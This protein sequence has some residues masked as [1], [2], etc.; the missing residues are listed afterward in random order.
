MGHRRKF[1]RSGTG[2]CL[3][4][5]ACLSLAAAGVS[6]LGAEP[7]GERLL[8]ILDASTGKP[9]A[10]FRVEVA[11]TVQEQVR[12]LQGRDGLE[13]GR[14]MLFLYPKAA[15]RSFWMKDVAFH[16][17]LVFADGE[18]RITEVLEDLRPCVGPVMRC[19]SYRSGSPAR[20]ALELAAGQADA[21]GLGPGDRLEL[22]P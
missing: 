8:R 3:V 11:R 12:G 6:A 22:A 7:P 18:G 2:R 13:P 15:P 5:V 19:P 4:L 10:T 17:D 16:I 21:H 9:K 14:G 20:Y 1:L